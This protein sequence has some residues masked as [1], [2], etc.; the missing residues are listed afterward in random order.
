MTAGRFR[1]AVVAIVIV[2]ALCYG[3]VLGA[4]YYFDDYSL[5]TD[6]VTQRDDGWRNLFDLER[7][8]PLTYLSFR[9]TFRSSGA[10]PRI[11]HVANLA[12]FLALIVSAAAVYRRLL[13][14]VPAAL[15]AGFLA[16]HPA[17]SEAVVYVFARAS[18]LAALLCVCAWLLWLKGRRWASVAAFALALLAKE[19][20]AGFVL[21]LAAFEALYAAAGRAALRR[22]AV[23]LAAMAA[24]VGAAFVRLLYAVRAT[25]ESGALAD[26]A[27]I[28]PMRYFWTQGP[29]LWGYFGRFAVPM[30]WNF[31]RDFAVAAGPDLVAVAAWAGLI[32]LAVLCAYRASSDRAYFWPLGALL[33]FL[34]TSS[35]LPLGDVT[36]DRRMLLPLIALAPGAGTVLSRVASGRRLAAVAVMMAVLL[37]ALTY[38]RA[39]VWSD[40]ETLWRDTVAKSPRKARPRLH[41]ARALERDGEGGW[42]E[43]EELLREA[44][45]LEP[46]SAR[47][48][49]ELGLF[50]LTSR[51]PGEA[52]EPLRR[53]VDLDPGA[54]Q[55]LANLGAAYYMTGAA[56]DAGAAFRRSLE[57][58]PCGFDARNNMILLERA[59][60]EAAR[61]LALAR[62]APP[63][64]PWSADQAAAMEAA[65]SR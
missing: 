42:S 12:L 61:A 11:D 23:P 9:A 20:A 39:R 65:R 7:T 28:T 50:L 54:A 2:A 13:G 3:P 35:L 58:D 38:R 32:A 4:P 41:L 37:A 51:R 27:G 25:P 63:D 45:D 21:F 34:P 43:R 40:A 31:D 52:V 44:N 36:A 16:L 30:G 14:P 24:L 56:D 47:A 57:I 55:A 1:L 46:D 8:R 33:L 64:C 49:Q 18:L 10:D 59:R 60:G 53:A 22:S 19:E 5:F 15:A 62:Q 26:V 48:A 17:A 29:A 6:P